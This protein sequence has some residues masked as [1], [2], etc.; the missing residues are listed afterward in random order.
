MLATLLIAFREGLEAALIVGI[1]LGYLKKSGQMGRNRYVW[2]GVGAAVAVSVA[3]AAGIQLA[4]AE[5]EGRAEEIFEGGTMLLA[6]GVLTWMIYWMRYQARAL[7]SSLEREV[8]AAVNSG[9]NWGL[10]AVAFMAVFREGV[11][12]A[13]LLSATTFATDGLGALAGSVL[14]LLAAALLGWLI[15]AS[16]VRLNLRAFFNVTSVFLL[17]FAAGLLARGVHEFQE[18]GLLFTLNEHVWNTGF[19]LDET[20]SVG[21]VV[22]ILFGYTSRPSLESVIAYGLYW[23]LVIFGV[24]WWADRMAAQ[25]MALERTAIRE[26]GVAS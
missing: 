3:L 11:E 26:S 24:R 14:G 18:A 6:V 9:Q 15:Y 20:S 13:L 1:L 16:T 10:A 22:N 8:Q 25:Q 19:I 4:G 2:I 5:L 7:K 17:V 21:Q 12:T 23:V